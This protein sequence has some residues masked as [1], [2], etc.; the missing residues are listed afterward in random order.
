MT[1][2]STAGISPTRLRSIQ[3]QSGVCHCTDCQ[4]LTGTVWRAGISS[5]P[6][7]FKLTSGTPKTY[8]KTAESR[9][10][11]AHGFCPECGTLILSTTPSRIH[12]SMGCGWSGP[13]STVRA[14]DTANNAAARQWIFD[15]PRDQN[16]VTAD[17]QSDLPRYADRCYPPVI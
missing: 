10:K 5:L 9:N 6:E 11:R 7:T 12:Q 4:K 1:G 17:D 15:R 8:I 2:G 16:S 3:R 14:T 13:A